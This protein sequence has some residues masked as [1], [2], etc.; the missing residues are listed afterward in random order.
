MPFDPE[1]VGWLSATDTL[2]DL[3]DW[4]SEEDILRLEEH[5][6]SIALYEA[7]EYK[8]HNNHWVIKQN[9][10]KLKKCFSLNHITVT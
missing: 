7:T 1:V 6:Y 4:F 5:G 2:E 8:L 9:S 10:S 3:F